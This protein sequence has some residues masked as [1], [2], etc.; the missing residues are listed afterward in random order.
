M[1]NQLDHKNLTEDSKEKAARISIICP[2]RNVAHYIDQTIK[3]VLSQSYEK[4]ELLVMDGASTD[5]TQE[6]VKRHCGDPRI[7]LF[8]EPDESPWDAT[9]K[10]IDRAKGEFVSIIAGQDGY[11]DKDWLKRCVDVFDRDPTIS[12]VWGSTRGMKED[13]T[14]LDPLHVSYS[15]LM[16][17][18]TP[19]DSVKH[20]AWK[21]LR[22]GSDLLFGDP[23]RKRILLK[24]MFSKTARLRF[25]FLS[26]R[27]FPNGE[28]PQK[29]KWYEYWLQT[30]FI[31]PDQAMIVKKRVYR[32]CAPRYPKGSRMVNHMTDFNYNFNTKGYLP[33]FLPML[34]TF[35]RFHQGNS[36]ARVSEELYNESEEYLRKV[37]RLRTNKGLKHIKS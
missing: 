21:S 14:L 28:V 30:G 13:G 29:E 6:V 20:L 12:L 34:A 1:G 2:T 7:K 4:W 16:K 32:E 25:N 37:M 22:I 5:G 35:G 15:H 36:G 24:K 9:D 27:S 18:E 23:V 17:R 3:S 8:S 31:F 33:Y 11:L 26:S 19:L 10:G